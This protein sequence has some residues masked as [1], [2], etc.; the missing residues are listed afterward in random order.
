MR[1]LL[2]FIGFVV[3][4]P[5]WDLLTTN[6]NRSLGP[7]FATPSGMIF[8]IV[9]GGSAD[10]HLVHVTGLLVLTGGA[11]IAITGMITSSRETK[12]GNPVQ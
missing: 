4:I 8:W 3:M 9:T 10:V 6:I 11:A 1:P 12:P 5:G 2:A 7:G